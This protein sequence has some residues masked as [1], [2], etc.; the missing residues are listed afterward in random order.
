MSLFVLD[1]SVAVSWVI[2]EA[3]TDP[4]IALRESVSSGR[5]DIIAPETFASEVAHALTK[6][7]RRKIIPEGDALK[8]LMDILES[9][10]ILVPFLSL[11]SRA[12]EISS[13]TRI[14][15]GDCLFIA[16]SEERGC[17]L[18]TADLRLLNSATDFNVVSIHS[19][20]L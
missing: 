14:A 13:A 4:A 2:P 12:V 17:D 1:S 8:H 10:P 15:V 3:A 19:L 7:E 16:L 11:L 18:I 6:A 9:G 20:G 5:H